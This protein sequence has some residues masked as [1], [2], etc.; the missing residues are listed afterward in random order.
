V[1]VPNGNVSIC[2]RLSLALLVP[3]LSFCSG[4]G[5]KSVRAKEEGARAAP[6]ENPPPPDPGAEARRLERERQAKLEK[7]FPLHG[8]VTGV[9]LQIRTEPDPGATI[10]GWLRIGSRVRMAPGPQKTRTCSSG[11]YRLH[12]QGWACAGEGIEVGEKPPDSPLPVAPPDD[13][14]PLP[15]RYYFVKE[16]YV[17]EYHRLPSRDEQRAA[18]DFIARYRKIKEA[19]E[20]RAARYRAEGLPGE[21]PR[22][23]VVHKLLERGF[24]VAGA[25]IE[26][27]AFRKFVRTVRGRYLKQAQM[28]ERTGGDF[29][30]VE[31][32]GERTLPVAWAIRSGRP[33]V[34][35]ERGDGT[36]RLRA[37]EEA[38]PIE[39]LTLLKTV[40]KERVGDHI[41]HQLADGRYLK[42]WFVA[43][44]DRIKRP[45]GVKPDE[46][47]VH[48]NLETQT[49][50]LYRGNT[51]VY[52]TL[53]STG[54]EG[55]DTPTGTFR[56]RS[57]HVADT[58]SDLGPD[59][60]DERYKIEDVPF[61]QYFS[62][63]VALHGAFWHERFGLR[64]SHGCI[65]LS[66]RDARRVFEHTE[67]ALPDGWHGI[68]TDRT[69]LRGSVV[70]ITAE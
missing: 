64:R 8:L 43:V 65:N 9:Q 4:D 1:P 67:P 41:F 7:E 33:F 52:A 28:I 15:Y 50:V 60:G 69:G 14:A 54:L 51:P 70:H 45:P 34:P 38:E 39:R 53:V 12:P 18:R 48:V 5:E 27:R 24:F 59:A 46:P 25:G 31:L 17:P 42:V 19:K 22:P 62:G 16:P 10:L 47:W 29:R 21:P 49:L 3:A 35:I 68:S 6:A 61:T 63:S 2:T 66:P 26:E 56:I 37:D 36:L 55:H 44:A 32:D 20:E 11:W 57:K 23:A 58:M 30:G 13:D 40:K